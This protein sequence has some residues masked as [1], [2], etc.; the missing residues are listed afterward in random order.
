MNYQFVVINTCKNRKQYMIKW[1][2]ILNFGYMIIRGNR[3]NICDD[4]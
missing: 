4:K 3:I 1:D 2:I